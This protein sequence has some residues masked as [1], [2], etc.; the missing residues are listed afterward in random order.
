MNLNNSL[1]QLKWNDFQTNLPL[2]LQYA[3][4]LQEFSDVTL[5]CD[6]DTALE[7]HRIILI[8]G[9]QFFEKV[10]RGSVTGKHSHPLLYLR[11]FQRDELAAILDYLY[12]GEASIQQGNLNSFL[13]I[14]HQLGI[15]GLVAETNGYNSENHQ[16]AP[17]QKHE[18][19]VTINTTFD[20]ETKSDSL[21]NIESLEGKPNEETVNLRITVD[22]LQKEILKQE[23][24]DRSNWILQ[25]VST[26]PKLPIPLNKLM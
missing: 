16:Y 20:H 24:T 3:R 15:K 12:T 5:V 18:E 23:A 26:F 19:P 22:A 25:N 10:L 11:G 14:A 4:E 2:S 1:V 21:K 6:D 7:A 13:A 9:S 8:A 17:E